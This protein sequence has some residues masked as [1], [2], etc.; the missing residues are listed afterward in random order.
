MKDNSP[1]PQDVLIKVHELHGSGVCLEAILQQVRKALLPPPY[2]MT[3][4]QSAS[5][6]VSEALKTIIFT[7]QYRCYI[8]RSM[9]EGRNHSIY[10]YIPEYNKTHG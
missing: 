10:V 1:A 4:W 7:Y 8:E 2:Q 5:N 6:A 9:K 3:K